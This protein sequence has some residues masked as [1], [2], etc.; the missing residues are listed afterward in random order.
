M[1]KPAQTCKKC[2]ALRWF[3]MAAFPLIGMIYFQPE[4]AMRLASRAP[5]IDMF[6]YLIV[7]ACFG[8]FTLKWVAFKREEKAARQPAVV[9]LRDQNE[10]L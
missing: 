7:L 6:G 10:T 4:G 9:R 1:R 3:F 8:L 5:S 2:I